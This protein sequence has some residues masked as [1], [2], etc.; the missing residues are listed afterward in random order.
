MFSWA[1]PPAPAPAS[2]SAEMASAV[3]AAVNETTARMAS[4]HRANLRKVVG[5]A[6][7]RSDERNRS[8]VDEAHALAALH[9]REATA[10]IGALA[11]E[12]PVVEGEVRA[13]EAVAAGLTAEL[14][15]ERAASAHFAQELRK[16]AL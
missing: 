10:F 13:A 3:Q 1:S 4:A 12:L 16:Q 8:R 6:V 11:T 7:A 5:E 14:E 2:P 15:A 9:Q